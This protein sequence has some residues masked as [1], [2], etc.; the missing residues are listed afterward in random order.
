MRTWCVVRIY[1]RVYGVS[2]SGACVSQCVILCDSVHVCLCLSAW[3]CVSMC[4]CECLCV[5]ICGGVISGHSI[6]SKTMI[7]T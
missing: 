3:V 6:F 2:G 4:L 7:T 5:R 1:I